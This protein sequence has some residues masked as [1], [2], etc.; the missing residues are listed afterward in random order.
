MQCSCKLQKNCNFFFI[1]IS[2]FFTGHR[3]APRKREKLSMQRT[4]QSIS[5][6]ACYCVLFSNGLDKFQSVTG[7]EGKTVVLGINSPNKFRISSFNSYCV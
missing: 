3:K 4:I 5:W 2:F 6:F 1:I 7:T